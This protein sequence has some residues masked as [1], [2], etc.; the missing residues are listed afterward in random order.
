MAFNMVVMKARSNA[1][2]TS[3]VLSPVKCGPV[4]DGSSQVFAVSDYVVGA[5]I[6]VIPDISLIYMSWAVQYTGFGFFFEINF[7][8]TLRIA[9]FSEASQ[10]HALAAHE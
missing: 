2:V 7:P 10:G 4:S 5:L 3:A 9:V 1:P 8:T 6:T